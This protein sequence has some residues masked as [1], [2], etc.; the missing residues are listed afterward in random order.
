MLLLDLGFDIKQHVDIPK[1][2]ADIAKLKASNQAEKEQSNKDKADAS[3]KSDVVKPKKGKGVVSHAAEWTEVRMEMLKQGVEMYEDD[4]Y[5][6]LLDH[7]T[8]HDMRNQWQKMTAKLMK[9]AMPK[10]HE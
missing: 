4:E 7:F 5:K 6:D 2:L 9:D 3:E 1:L 10:P 8:Q